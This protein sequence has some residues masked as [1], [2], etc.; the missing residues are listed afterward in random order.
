MS[1][2]RVST[3]KD[4]AY[5]PSDVQ[6]SL[7]FRDKVPLKLNGGIGAHFNKKIKCDE[8]RYYLCTYH[9]H[10]FHRIESSFLLDITSDEEFQ[11]ALEFHFDGY[12][13]IGRKGLDGHILKPD[14]TSRNFVIIRGISHNEYCFMKSFTSTL[15]SHATQ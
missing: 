5:K 12:V 15:R 6:I 1:V 13:K 11:T 4:S 3:N 10:G 9:S 2:I 14:D 8:T 7:S